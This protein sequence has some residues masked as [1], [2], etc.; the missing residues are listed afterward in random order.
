MIRHERVSSLRRFLRDASGG[1][2]LFAGLAA[3]PLIGSVGVA[4]DVSTWYGERTRL[5]SAADSAALA[6]AREMRLANTPADQLEDAAE[7]TARAAI[8]ATGADVSRSEVVAV[9]DDEAHAVRVTIRHELARVFSRIVT[10]TFTRVEVSAVARVSGS[11]PICVIGLDPEEQRTLHFEQRALLDARGCAVYSNSR[12]AQGM[13]IANFAEINA[14]LIC[15]AGGKVGPNAA[16]RPSPRLDCPPL[17]D[18]LASRVAP[19]VGHCTETDL[20]VRHDRRLSPGV[21]CGGIRIENEANVDLD[22]G[23]YI[24]KDGPL[25]V[26][27]GALVGRYTSF[28]FTGDDAVLEFEQE[29]TIDLTAMRDGGLAGILF[30]EDRAAPVGRD[31]RITSDDARNLLGTIYLPRG[32]LFV[33]SDNSVADHSAFTVIVARKLELSEAPVLTLNT[34][35][36]A[37][38]IPVPEGVGPT[39]DVLLTE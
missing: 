19:S 38:D 21:Y 30:F 34:D 29:S 32:D 16:Y 33:N 3:I 18:P 12:H 25:V 10:D 37:T 13:R 8:A 39:G 35:Y 17:P 20:V 7:A 22:P 14:A 11:A 9:V 23:L 26:E 4:V 31:F 5:Q 15:S 1:V 2:A 27:E 36:G 6:A 24:L 28:Y